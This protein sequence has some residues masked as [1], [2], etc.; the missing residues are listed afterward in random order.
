MTLQQVQRLL[1]RWLVSLH[2]DERTALLLLAVLLLALLIFRAGLL[3]RLFRHLRRWLHRRRL[4]QPL[5]AAGRAGYVYVIRGRDDGLFKI[6]LTVDPAKRLQTF[7]TARPDLQFEHLIRCRDRYNAERRLHE[8]F[9]RKRR[10][11]EWFQ[12]DNR[13]LETLKRI[14]AL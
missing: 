9:A 1:H 6:G 8:Q 13:D 7:Q 12:L 4:P 3:P 2:L 10:Q 11:G 5:S 14:K